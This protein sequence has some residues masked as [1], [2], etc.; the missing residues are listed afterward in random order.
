MAKIRL[1]PSEYKI[2]SD[3]SVSNAANMYTNTDSDTYG[4]FT[5][6]GG[7]SSLHACILRG[8]NFSEIPADAVVTDWEVKL[9]MRA[10]GHKSELD[11]GEYMTL[12][13]G[14]RGSAIRETISDPRFISNDL[15]TY[16]FLKASLTWEQIK[17][18][19]Q[20]FGIRIPMYRASSDAPEVASVYGAEI[21][22]TIEG[23]STDTDKLYTKSNGAWAEVDTAYKKVNG[24]WVPQTDVTNVFQS[25][26]NYKKGN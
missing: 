8:F 5:N 14:S 21:E 7:T 18:Y 9:K 1:V 25:G 13:Q 12:A 11:T 23:G 16:T 10:E 6:N 20:Y 24:I 17:G 19:G 22:V 26:I 15:T 2:S 3:V 4:T